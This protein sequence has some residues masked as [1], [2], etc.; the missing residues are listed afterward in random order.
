MSQS[1][2]IDDARRRYKILKGLIDREIRYTKGYTDLNRLFEI[3]VLEKGMRGDAA[4][5]AKVALDELSRVVDAFG[6]LDI[7]ASFESA[8]VTH[9]DSLLAVVR[10]RLRDDVKNGHIAR[11]APDLL[12][13]VDDLKASLKRVFDVMTVGTH[14]AS[15]TKLEAVRE[16][17]NEIAHGRIP[18][19]VPITIDDLADLLK[20]LIHKQFPS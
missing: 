6:F 10:G 17:R 2:S 9:L 12:S 18:S 1:G 16:T 14:A 13:T 11:P 7:T 4:D 20:S 15:V 19:T 3:G 5:R 8:A